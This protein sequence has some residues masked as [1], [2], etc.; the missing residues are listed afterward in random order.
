MQGLV[1]H[2]W[3]RRK[4]VMFASCLGGEL[5]LRRLKDNEVLRSASA[6]RNTI[7]ALEERGLISPGKLATRSRSC[8]K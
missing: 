6:N 5:V 2:R 7:K 3:Q 4:L 1:P 8:A